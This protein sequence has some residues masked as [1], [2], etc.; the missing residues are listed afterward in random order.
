M[1]YYVYVLCLKVYQVELDVVV[2]E[3]STINCSYVYSS[4]ANVYI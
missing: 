4:D 3:G 2:C 1:A